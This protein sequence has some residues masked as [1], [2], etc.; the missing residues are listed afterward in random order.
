[1]AKKAQIESER[2][3][4]KI[5]M[6][7]GEFEARTQKSVVNAVINEYNGV[8]VAQN[9]DWISQELHREAVDLNRNFAALFENV[10]YELANAL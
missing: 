6:L 9:K 7:I 2:H 1:V 4:S 10:N 5:R 3:A 8:K